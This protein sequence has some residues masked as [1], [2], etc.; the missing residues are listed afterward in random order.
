MS[1]TARADPIGTRNVLVRSD[2]GGDR[3]KDRLYQRPRRGRPAGHQAGSLQRALFAAGD[4]GADVQQ[5]LGFDALGAL[6]GS[7]IKGVAAVDDHVARRKQRQQLFDD[8]IDRRPGL[9]HQHHFARRCEILDQLFDRVAADEVLARGAAG[10]EGIDD[11]GGAVVHGDAIAPALDVERQ[12]LA[13]HSQTDQSDVAKLGHVVSAI[14]IC[15]ARVVFRAGTYRTRPTTCLDTRRR[16]C[17]PG[18]GRCLRRA[19]VA[20]WFARRRD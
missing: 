4:A 8:A 19:A 13:H 9:D 15:R 17:R 14:P 2:V 12:V 16:T 20:N 1:G 11:A 7:E 18:S 3:L 10:D 6:L 5:A